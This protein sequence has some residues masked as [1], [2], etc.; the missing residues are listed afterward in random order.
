MSQLM[1]QQPK[2]K[3]IKLPKLPAYDNAKDN[4]WEKPWQYLLNRGWLFVGN[5]NNPQSLWFDPTKSTENKMH[6][7]PYHVMGSDPGNPKGSQIVVRT[8]TRT[9]V[10][11]GASPIGREEAVACQIIRDA[12]LEDI[13][14]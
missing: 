5:P 2:Y 11:P 3:P 12:E 6:K 1:S 7:E 9:I 10:T 13:K 8:I 4:P 14:K